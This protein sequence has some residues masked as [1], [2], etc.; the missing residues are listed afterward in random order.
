MNDALKTALKA[1]A[2]DF[3]EG[4]AAGAIT[5]FLA[6]GNVTD[7]KALAYIVVLGAIDGAISALRRKVVA[8]KPA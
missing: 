3:A 7:P 6:A 2:V 8:A 4:A 5:A 1:F